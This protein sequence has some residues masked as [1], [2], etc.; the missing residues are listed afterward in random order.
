MTIMD[1]FRLRY[2]R[3]LLD[4]VLEVLEG[5]VALQG[6]YLSRPIICQVNFLELEAGHCLKLF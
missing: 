5:L 3:H 2:F 1:S 4:S 6:R